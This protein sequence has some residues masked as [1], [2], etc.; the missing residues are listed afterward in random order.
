MSYHGKLITDDKS[1]FSRATGV[2]K[3]KLIADLIVFIAVRSE[4]T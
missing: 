1:H 4:A 3:R 2:W